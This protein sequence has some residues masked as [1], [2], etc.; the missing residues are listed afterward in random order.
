M[1]YGKKKK[2]KTVDVIKLRV[3]RWGKYPELSGWVLN[4]IIRT[5]IRGRQGYL[6]TEE[7]GSVTTE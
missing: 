7:A 3:L 4:I 6:S 2:K 5:L 1:L